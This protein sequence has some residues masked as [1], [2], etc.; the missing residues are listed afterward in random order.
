[1][2]IRSLLLSAQ[3]ILRN[4]PLTRP[5]RR[6]NGRLTS[7]PRHYII[8]NNSNMAEHFQHGR[9]PPTTP[10]PQLFTSRLSTAFH[11]YFFRITHHSLYLPA[12]P[13]HGKPTSTR[14]KH[15]WIPPPR[16]NLQLFKSRLSTTFHGYLCRKTSPRGPI[17]TVMAHLKRSIVE[18]K[19]EENCLAH[20]FITAINR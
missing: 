12:H 17:T 10:N 14:P 16:E 3:T 8:K 18:V 1:L 2:R 7:S 4:Y 13:H 6:W 19:G 15:R 9:L 20:T 5:R 11:A